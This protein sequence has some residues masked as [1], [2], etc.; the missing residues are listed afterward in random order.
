MT[1]NKA[2]AT[3]KDNSKSGI[4]YVY[5]VYSTNGIIYREIGWKDGVRKTYTENEFLSFHYVS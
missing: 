3:L 2:A 4:V 5:K 1:T